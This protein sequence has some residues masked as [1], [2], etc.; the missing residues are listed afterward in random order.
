[1]IYFEGKSPAHTW[2]NTKPYME[3]YDHPL[4][5]RYSK[6]AEGAGHGGM[7]FFVDN[8]FIECLKRDAEFPMDIY[9]LATWYAITPLSEKS[10][11]E[12]GTLQHIPDF[13]DGAWERR[14]PV[15]CLDDKY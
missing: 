15:F 6:D 1:L 5:K 7:D 9:D 8:S 13:T 11:A 14:K 3:Q 2:E 10:I 4:W 12:G